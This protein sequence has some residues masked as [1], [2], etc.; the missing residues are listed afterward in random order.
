MP[1]NESLFLLLNV[2]FRLSNWCISLTCTLA[3][4]N[5]G[6]AASLP[7]IYSLL[8]NIQLAY[9]RKAPKLILP[10]AGSS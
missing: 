3:F 4:Q 5:N 7:P 6:L 9:A 1:Q 10:D 8:A 2:R